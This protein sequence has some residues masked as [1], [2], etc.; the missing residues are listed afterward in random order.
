MKVIIELDLHRKTDVSWELLPD[1]KTYNLYIYNEDRT[2]KIVD[3]V[4]FP[5]EDGEIINV[6]EE[7]GIVNII[8]EAKGNEEED[9]IC[10]NEFIDFNNND[11]GID[12][13]RDAGIM[14]IV[15]FSAASVAIQ[16]VVSTLNSAH[17]TWSSVNAVGFEATLNGIAQS[18]SGNSRNFIGLDPGS[19]HTFR[20]RARNSAG[21]WSAWVSS[22]LR[23]LSDAPLNIPATS[24]HNS[25]SVRVIPAFPAGATGYD[26]EFNGI[27]QTAVRERDFNNTLLN[28]WI[29]TFTDLQPNT[30]YNYR[31]RSRNTAGIGPFSSMQSVRTL[32][33]TPSNLRVAV[34]T[35]SSLTI[36]WDAVNGATNYDISFDRVIYNVTGTRKT[37]TDLEINTRHTVN[38][39]ARSANN[40][41]RVTGNLQ[42]TTLPPVPQSITSGSSSDAIS[43]SWL[44]ILNVTGYEI[45]FD[46]TYINVS[47]NTD[48]RRIHNVPNLIPN[49]EYHFKVRAR[50]AG[51]NG[52]FSEEH[53]RYTLL[54]RPLNLRA[55]SITETSITMQWDAVNGAT[56]YDV[57]VGG[58]IHNVSGTIGTFN[59]LD[60]STRYTI[61]VR[62]RNSH[63]HSAVT[64]NVTVTT[65]PPVPQNITTTSTPVSVMVAWDRILNA[66]GYE[67]IFN[68]ETINVTANAEARRGHTISNLLPD[69]RHRFRVRA[70]NISGNGAFSDEMTASTLLETATVPENVRV[71]GTTT[72]T[73]S[74]EWDPVAGINR[75]EVVVDR[76]NVFSTATASMTLRNL[77]PNRSHTI[78]V[79]SANAHTVSALSRNITATTNIAVPVVTATAAATSVTVGW[80][81]V[82]GATNYDI[83]FNGN[84]LGL[85]NVTSRSFTGLTPETVHTFSVTS[86]NA[87]GSSYPSPK[88]SI[89]TL[90]LA[91]PVPV[92]VTATATHNTVTVSWDA[93]PRATEYDVV[94][95][96]TTFT[97][98]AT[99]RTFTNLASN[100]NFTFRVR[101][102]NAGG[103]SVLSVNNTI[104]T[105]IAPPV[106]PSNIRA[107][108]VSQ[109]Q[110]TVVWNPVT[111]ATGYDIS[112]D[113]NIINNNTATSRLFN[114]LIP[115]RNY[116]VRV[117]SRG[118]GGNG[119]FSP[120]HVFRTVSLSNSNTGSM[121]IFNGRPSFSFGDPIDA[122]NGAFLW[123]FT[124]LSIDAKDVME[125]QINYNSKR[126]NNSVLGHK[127]NHSMGF[128]LDI[129][130]NIACF[131][132]PS[133]EV[134]P[135]IF[136]E[137]TQSFLPE[138]TDDRYSLAQKGDRYYVQSI[139]NEEYVFTSHLDEIRLNNIAYVYLTH[140]DIGQLITITGQY[141]SSFALNYDGDKLVSI[142][143]PLSRA[144]CFEYNGDNLIHVVNPANDKLTF[145]YDDSGNLT[146]IYDY[147]GVNY[148]SNVYSS[149]NEVL[150]QNLIERG[151]AGA[152]FNKTNRVNSYTDELGN[153]IYYHLDE[154]QN[155]SVVD[156]ALGSVEYKR[157]D[158]E[159]ITEQTDEL[160]IVTKFTYDDNQRLSEVSYT[161]GTSEATEYND[162]NMPTKI[163]QTDDTEVM[164][165]YDERGNLLIETDERG[166]SDNFVYDENDNIITHTDKNGN[167]SF[168]TYDNT[169]Q[170]KTEVDPLGNTTKHIYDAVGNLVYTESP[171][172]RPTSYKYNITG[173]LISVAQNGIT[174]TFTYDENGN[175]TSITDNMG[176]SKHYIYD[177]MSNVVSETDFMGNKYDHVY[178]EKGLLTENIDPLEFKEYFEY[179]ELGNVICSV[180]KNGNAT[181]NLY[182]K[183][184]QLVEVQMPLNHTTKYKYNKLGYVIAETDPNGNETYFTYDKAGRVDSIIN[185]LGHITAFTYDKAG[186]IL[187][188]T[189]TNGAV[190]RYTYDK[191]NNLIN[192]ESDKGCKRLFYD[193]AGQL[194]SAWD[195]NN[196]IE[197][198]EYDADGNV[199]SYKDKE[200]NV[201][202]YIYNDAGLLAGEINALGGKTVYEYDKNG[203]KSMITDPNNNS[204][205]YSYNA[206]G[207]LIKETDP[208]GG[209]TLH[210]YNARGD[211]IFKTDANGNESVFEYDGN[212]NVIKE[213]NPAGGE[214]IYTYD[215]L[216]R[217]SN[218]TDENGYENSFK[219]DKAGNQIENTDANGIVRIFEYDPLNRPIKASDPDGSTCLSYD[220]KENI[221]EIIASDGAVSKYEYDAHDRITKIYDAMGNSSEFKYDIKNNIT[222]RTDAN[223]N[224]T[225]MTYSP[226]GNLCSV[227][228]PEGN[229][230]TYFYNTMGWVTKKVDPSG[231]VTEYDY[232]AVGH[233]ISA[234][235]EEG[236]KIHFTYNPL[237]EIASVTDPNGNKT[238]YKYDYNGNL[239]QTVDANGEHF[240]YEYDSLNN[241]TKLYN[242]SNKA[243]IIFKYDKKGQMI[244]EILPT[245]AERS[246]EYDGNGNVV[247]RIDEDN[248][249]T[250][251]EYNLSNKPVSVLFADGKNIQYRY[252]CN[253]DL[254]ELNDWNGTTAFKRDIL[255]RIINVTDHNGYSSTYTYD[256]VGNKRSM[257]YPDGSMVKYA[258]D[259]NNRLK[260]VLDSDNDSTLF[261]YNPDGKIA[262]IVQ[263]NGD[264]TDYNYNSLGAINNLTY[265]SKLGKRL[266]KDFVFDKAGNIVLTTQSIDNP[267]VAAK[268]KS[269]NYDKINQLVSYTEDGITINYEYDGNGNRTKKTC[270]SGSPETNYTYNELNQLITKSKGDRHYLYNYDKRG[271]LVSELVNDTTVNAYTFDITDRM[272]EGKNLKTGEHSCYVYNGLGVRVNNND[273]EYIPDY[274][275]SNINN[276]M[277]IKDGHVSTLL[278]G[279]G[280]DRICQKLGYTSDKNSGFNNL[281]YID[282][283][284]F[285]SN[286]LG[287]TVFASDKD[288]NIIDHVMFDPWGKLQSQISERTKMNGIG[289]ADRFTG[290]TYDPVI[291]K[292]FAKA[293]FY[294]PVNGRM[295][296]IDPV[297]ADRNLYRYALNNPL[298]N[299]DL[300]GQLPVALAGF[301]TKLLEILRNLSMR[302]LKSVIASMS[303]EFAIQ[304]SR[305]HRGLGFNGDAILRAAM[306]GAASSTLRELSYLNRFIRNLGNHFRG[307]QAINFFT[308][309]FGTIIGDFPSG[310]PRSTLWDAFISGLAGAAHTSLSNR[311]SGFLGDVINDI[312]SIAHGRSIS[313]LWD[314]TIGFP[315]TRN[316][317]PAAVCQ[318]DR[319]RTGTGFEIQ[320]G[321]R[322]VE[323][324][325]RRRKFIQVRCIFTGRLMWRWR[326]VRVRTWRRI[327]TVSIVSTNRSAQSPSTRPASISSSPRPTGGSKLGIIAPTTNRPAQSSSIRSTPRSSINSI[328]V[329]TSRLNQRLSNSSL[330][331]LTP[332]PRQRINP[333]IRRPLRLPAVTRSFTPPP[334]LRHRP[335]FI[336][337]RSNVQPDMS[338]FGLPRI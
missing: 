249:K 103:Q 125:F 232:D 172:G 213:I 294:D 156:H 169:G 182:S 119:D 42:A 81:T 97:T 154:H 181:I 106:F 100:T 334:R 55:T 24:T 146:D 241:V 337:R 8:V 219:Y 214:T 270:S 32:L 338:V 304:L 108:N 135:F 104:R 131:T 147:S 184:S 64:G 12:E 92:N 264:I 132:K 244:K 226:N 60:P 105:L 253:G 11:I 305:H 80:N 282:K 312:L 148:L 183:S 59:N 160:G 5:E 89:S 57:S 34:S 324:W 220:N 271:N 73:I 164:F 192:I 308:N 258:Y 217:I 144:F 186:N 210:K 307:R 77:L 185:A 50:N 243:P 336:P 303:S 82:P 138:N 47:A 152:S 267:S 176:N 157:N 70:R 218:I 45:L 150:E 116:R 322:Y 7:I 126:E 74:L 205:Y 201:T 87:R 69:T 56:N 212:G 44:R 91:P 121:G 204:R 18:V 36:E 142:K 252:N 234:K 265:S 145:S 28:S 63:N 278:Y 293:R 260:S 58:V 211:L 54:E 329:S 15:P 153:T 10:F 230:E 111:G 242:T 313:E 256:K 223:G 281:E 189:D 83:T 330:L 161:D 206:N 30:L 327:P 3:T 326:W 175:R 25:V 167:L 2:Q 27:I 224:V 291:D 301:L 79:R 276:I 284:Y 289:S 193:A 43:I 190:T 151:T 229:I 26:V 141:G 179:D 310:V 255:G 46:G 309:L 9:I 14:A 166:N 17:V 4:I 110:M 275:S 333:P 39:R 158:K 133:G 297:Y 335:P 33:E 225:K 236:G 295:I 71:V 40:E 246:Y 118:A 317:N 115:G 88:Q 235:D 123:N 200:G 20:I 168:F 325:T 102:R 170:L 248:N 114:N 245:H 159:Q 273:V 300:D 302:V 16:S 216:D 128:S 187:S 13:I 320:R 298:I 269:Y 222:E 238:E 316:R 332:R 22:T 29:S 228:D 107:I 239:L 113:G 251:Y 52:A 68:G 130:D 178:N 149:E 261:E 137:S 65:L 279:I 171:M 1:V 195:E 272:V 41:S 231:V 323:V 319:A 180:D 208:M 292:Y 237:G 140:N 78:N 221:I 177:S 191:E 136:D 38:V 202:T 233:V 109:R 99:S 124:L 165:T 84:T 318:N 61:N 254:I 75:Y 72:S 173:D 188:E 286:I 198:S 90:P 19:A 268:V 209:E 263:P 163:K 274:T 321:H 93:A 285:Q 283:I 199:S 196:N 76:V 94:F 51:G 37:F 197:T 21:T 62:A 23:T 227:T 134:I 257:L 328:R 155:V 35:T 250:V 162:F 207:D 67:V 266:S 49:T 306:Q 315:G 174:A 66:T 314:H 86:R 240:F 95:G 299:I 143:D 117:R 262:K 48:A 98:S 277:M 215:A 139:E 122:T 129:K 296:S 127:W 96:G 6:P 31:V 203:N 101:A 290:H 280:H 247:Q 311:F 53:S 331:R 112:F 259:K 120:I 287:N 85:G 288:G 194:V